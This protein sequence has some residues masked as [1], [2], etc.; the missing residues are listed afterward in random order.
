MKLK[1]YQ[2]FTQRYYQ[3]REYE[4][5]D[6]SNEMQYRLNNWS[7]Y[8]NMTYSHEYGK[9]RESSSRI[10][11]YKTEYQLSVGHTYKQ[12]LPDLP[13]ST[14]ANDMSLSFGYTVNEQVKLNGGFTYDVDDGSNNQWRFGGSYHRDCWNVAASIRQD[15]TPRPTG[16]STDNS[17][18]VQ[19]NFIPFGSMGT[20]DP[21]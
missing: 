3:D 9:I 16:Y 14:S 13:T 6:M 12:I 4:L 8:N 21:R 20:G 17:F 18:Y 5:S 15:I 19:M 2:R 10:G 1:F 7:L 11:L